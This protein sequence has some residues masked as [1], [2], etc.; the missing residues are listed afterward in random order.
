MRTPRVSC[1][2]EKC[3]HT[4]PHAYY[5]TAR[6]AI[7]HPLAFAVIYDG[8]QCADKKN[9]VRTDDNI[10]LFSVVIIYHVCSLVFIPMSA[11]SMTRKQYFHVPNLYV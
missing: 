2:R 11:I 5:I 8:V 9:R 3:T 4:W 10:I 6:T 1:V 7:R